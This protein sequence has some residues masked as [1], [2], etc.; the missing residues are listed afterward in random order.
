MIPITKSRIKIFHGICPRG[1]YEQFS[2]QFSVASPGGSSTEG[3][4]KSVLQ[5]P[6]IIKHKI[7]P[8]RTG[9]DH[10]VENI[11]AFFLLGLQASRPYLSLIITR[12]FLLFQRCGLGSEDAVLGG[13]KNPCILTFHLAP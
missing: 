9:S 2:E 5:N 13:K 1:T 3:F 7:L 4:S 11:F 10:R 8:S 12:F 6:P